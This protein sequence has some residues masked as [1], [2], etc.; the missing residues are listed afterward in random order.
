MERWERRNANFERVFNFEMLVHC[1]VHENEKDEKGE[2]NLIWMTM[3][4]LMEVPGVDRD[5]VD[6]MFQEF[7][8]A[9]TDAR[10]TALEPFDN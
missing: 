9:R 8:D 2:D 4:T 1:K 3:P 6:K 7:D 10:C 5:E